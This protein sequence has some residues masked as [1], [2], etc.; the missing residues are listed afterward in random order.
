MASLLWDNDALLDRVKRG[1]SIPASQS[2]YSDQDLLDVATDQLLSYVMPLLEQVGRDYHTVTADVALASAADPARHT[3]PHR[4]V[5]SQLRD[6]SIVCS[7]GD[8]YPL[9]EVSYV[10]RWQYTDS[11]TTGDPEVYWFDGDSVRLSPQP[12]AGT[13]LTLRLSYSVRPGRLVSPSEAGVVAS[14]TATTIVLSSTPPAD[15]VTGVTVDV[16][17][18]TAGF[19]PKAIGITSSD[20]TSNTMTFA[21]EDLAGHVIV[22]GDYVSV[23]EETP[24]VNLPP[25]FHQLVHQRT[26]VK[27][28]EAQ[29]EVE[30]MQIAQQDLA[31]IEA[32]TIQIIKG[33]NR[34][35]PPRL[36]PSYN[37]LTGASA[38]RGRTRWFRG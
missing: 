30:R 20:V 25:D 7:N 21:S 12:S 29:G 18:G 28:L 38:L 19:L 23:T 1:A 31:G 22:A 13:S 11:S 37:L 16:I 14:T 2:T 36:K 4:A 3:I 5:G 32:R 27:I 10:D 15:L 6:V 34:G 35:E 24:V 8:V 17:S 9:R 33:R 26:I